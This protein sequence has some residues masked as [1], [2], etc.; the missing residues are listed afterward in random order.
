MGHHQIQV[1]IASFVLEFLISPE[2]DSFPISGTSSK[3]LCAKNCWLQINQ[4]SWSHTLSPLKYWCFG[5]LMQV[6]TF[7]QLN[8]NFFKN[9]ISKGSFRGHWLP[10]SPTFQN[11]FLYHVNVIIVNLVISLKTA[12]E[13]LTRKLCICPHVFPKVL[14]ALIAK[15]PITGSIKNPFC[16]FHSE[17]DNS[18]CSQKYTPG[19]KNRTALL[20][21]IL[22]N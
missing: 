11:Q 10:S 20:E 3:L 22:F 8:L 17:K 7:Q 12:S 16:F 19:K 14:S 9:Y 21:A 15:G 4:M 1:F 6:I 13:K 18:S 2:G 5:R